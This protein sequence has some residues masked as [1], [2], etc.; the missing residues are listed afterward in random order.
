MAHKIRIAAMSLWRVLFD[1][2][3]PERHYMRGPGP[4]W[5]LQPRACLDGAAMSR[6][7][8]HHASPQARG[9]AVRPVPTSERKRAPNGTGV[10][11]GRT[12]GTSKRAP[13]ALRARGQHGHNH[14]GR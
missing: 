2:Y 14:S 10:R 1:N 11:C 6:E 13:I 3:R 4:K 7:K 8:A 12:R 5:R 9:D